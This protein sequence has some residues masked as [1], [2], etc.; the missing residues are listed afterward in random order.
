MVDMFG[1]PHSPALHVL[2]RYRLID[3]EAMKQAADRDERENQRLPDYHP[4]TSA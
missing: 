2:E 4:M 3:N 1:T